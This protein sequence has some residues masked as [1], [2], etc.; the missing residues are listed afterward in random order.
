MAAL[1]DT[2]FS[3]CNVDRDRANSSKEKIAVLKGGAM[4]SVFVIFITDL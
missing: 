3:V 2:M 4:L 1:L